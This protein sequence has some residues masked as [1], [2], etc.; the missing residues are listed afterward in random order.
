MAAPAAFC[1][2]SKSAS[3]LSPLNSLFS[4]AA[5]PPRASG[6]REKRIQ[7]GEEGGKVQCATSAIW[8]SP[9]GAKTKMIQK[10]T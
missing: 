3:L 5:S 2:P 9:K 10:C 6:S 8:Q 4:A 1:G 7:G